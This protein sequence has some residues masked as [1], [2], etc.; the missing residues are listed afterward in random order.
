MANQTY[1][2]L[3]NL[4]LQSLRETPV[5]TV[6]YNSYSSL[7]GRWVN[8]A[9]RQVEDAW[10][11]QGLN[12][13][14]TFSLVPG[15]VG[16]SVNAITATTLYNSGF[17]ATITERTKV[18]QDVENPS[19]PMA[20]DVTAGQPMQLIQYPY[21]WILRARTVQPTPLVQATPIFFGIDHTSNN[22]H[23]ELLETPLVARDWIIHW[24]L[25][26]EDLFNDTDAMYVP[27]YPVVAIA[28]DIALGERGEEIGEPGNTS[29]QRAN[30]HIDNAIA[31]DSREQPHLTTFF[32]G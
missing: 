20:F 26:Q 10:P 7:V 28:T 3:V 11:W 16:Y 4:V 32:P 9:K 21:D 13:F 23:V 25:P 18:R 27:W 31:L 15:Q 17:G 22:T 12:A 30:L 24:T 2:Q 19:R 5:G 6:S 14:T 8:D 29:A 1:L